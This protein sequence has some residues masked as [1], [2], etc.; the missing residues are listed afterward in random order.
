M[1]KLALLSPF[2][3]SVIFAFPPHISPC[4]RYIYMGDRYNYLDELS[5]YQ[6][7]RSFTLPVFHPSTLLLFHSSN[8]QLFYSST[9][10]LFHPS[11]L[12]LF[13]Y[14]TLPPFHTSILPLFHSSTLPLF[15][16]LTLPLF[17]PSTTIIPL[18]VFYSSTDFSYVTLQL[19][20]LSFLCLY[21]F[22]LLSFRCFLPYTPDRKFYLFSTLLFALFVFSFCSCNLIN[23]LLTL[24]SLSLV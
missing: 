8:L 17:H 5:Q 3:P 14:S 15:H 18:S 19:S 11:T 1:E 9:L 13:H 7:T 10:P 22:L 16:S 12:P 6:Q 2:P 24:F 4:S 20:L 23:F 21:S